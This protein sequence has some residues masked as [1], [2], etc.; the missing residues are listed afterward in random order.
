MDGLSAQQLFGTGEGLTYKYVYTHLYTLIYTHTLC[1]CAMKWCVFVM[2]AP[3][4]VRI[5]CCT[6]VTAAFGFRTTVHRT[7]DH[8]YF[9]S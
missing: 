1:S 4:T 9:Q 2:R 8:Y 3:P 7:L 5:V 6:G